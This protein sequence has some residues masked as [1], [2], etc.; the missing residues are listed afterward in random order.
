V[1]KES[2]NSGAAAQRKGST[3]KRFTIYMSICG[4]QGEAWQ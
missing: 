1:E 4:H 2:L 3:V